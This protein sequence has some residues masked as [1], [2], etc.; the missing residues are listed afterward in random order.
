MKHVKTF[1]VSLVTVGLSIGSTMAQTWDVLYTVD[2]NAIAGGFFAHCLWNGD[3][4]ASRWNPI[5]SGNEQG[6]IYKFEWVGSAWSNTSTIVIPGV[7]GSYNFEGFTT[8]GQYIYAVNESNVIYKINP[9]T[10]TATTITISAEV[11]PVGIAYDA[12]NNGFWL[13]EYEGL[14]ATLVSMT[15]AAAGKTLT[16]GSKNASGIAYDD[17]TTGGPYLWMADVSDPVLHRWNVTTGVFEQDVHNV[18]DVSGVSQ[19]DNLAGLGIGIDTRLEKVVLLGV[20]EGSSNQIFGYDFGAVPT[21]FIPVT[22]IINVPNVATVGVPLPLTG[23]VEP[24]D[25]TNQTIVWSV[26]NSGTTGADI[27]GG[28]LFCTSIGTATIKATIINGTATG[29]YEQGF[30]IKVT[31]NTGID[32]ISANQISIYPNPTTGKLIINNGELMIEN[33][34]IFDI[35]GNIVEVYSCGRSNETEINISHLPAGIYYLRVNDRTV[36]VVKE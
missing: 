17:V 1:L 3:L 2:A 8:D 19:Y 18:T 16:N 12:A 10:W 22:G 29:D 34:K 4:Y 26:V 11:A 31:E 28:T 9:A 30:S 21:S 6:K 14:T 27:I 20:N 13:I 32:D 7:T 15:G 25:A 33:V 35:I 23:T 24:S 36:K 5:S